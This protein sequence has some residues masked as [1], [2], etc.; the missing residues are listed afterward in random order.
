MKTSTRLLALISEF[1]MVPIEIQEKKT[2]AIFDKI[3]DTHSI[4]S[5]TSLADGAIQMVS[6]N[7][8]SNITRY[9][10][11]KDRVVLSYEFCENTLNYYQGLL[12]DFFSVFTKETNINTFL[13]HSIIIR[14]LVNIAGIEDSRRFLIEKVFSLNNE[15]L[16]CFKKPLHMFG[17]RFFFPG[18]TD[19][20]TAFD[21]R[22]E[23]VIDDS[24]TFFIE[25]KGIFP[26]PSDIG[27]A[28]TIISDDVQ[29]TDNFIDKN[30]VNFLIQ[31]I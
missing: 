13:M 28:A 4:G 8:K 5:Y 24:K 3:S 6:K 18:T 12:N 7:Q 20:N 15:N 2:R 9:T 23:T 14:K 31:F 11:M 16:Q 26:K 25:N 30:I 21:V 10:I 19:D 29:S 27:H 17:S 1:I 22:I